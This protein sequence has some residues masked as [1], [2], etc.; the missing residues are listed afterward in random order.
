MLVYS[1]HP[2]RAHAARALL[3]GQCH[4]TTGSRRLLLAYDEISREITSAARPGVRRL[5]ICS[6]VVAPCC[7]HPDV[8]INHVRYAK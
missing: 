7:A 2:R 6:A 3:I 1:G 8:L 4:V 5:S